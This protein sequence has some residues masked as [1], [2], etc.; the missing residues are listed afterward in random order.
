[1]TVVRLERRK[2][3]GKHVHRF[4]VALNRP[5]LGSKRIG[6][7]RL[8]SAL[9]LRLIWQICMVMTHIMELMVINVGVAEGRP[10]LTVIL[11]MSVEHSSSPAFVCNLG[12]R[13][14]YRHRN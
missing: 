1:M 2:A 6:K 9:A 8:G 4:E 5:E 13:E 10:S 11:R 3:F 7:L 12:R 14:I